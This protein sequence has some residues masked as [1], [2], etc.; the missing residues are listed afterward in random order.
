MKAV[1]K[2]LETFQ[3]A[4]V[5]NA[6]EFLSEAAM[7]KVVD[8]AGVQRPLSGASPFYAIIDL[9]CPDEQSESLIMT[10]FEKCAGEELIDDGVM[11][12]NRLQAAN[13]WRCREEISATISR[14]TP[15]KNDISVRVSRAPEFLQEIDEVVARH[16]PNFEVIWYGHMGDG[17][18]HLN[19]LKP[20]EISSSDFLAQC[21]KVNEW[22]YG[23]VRKHEGSVSAEHGIG[24]LKKNAL[25]YSRSQEEVRLMK[26]IKAVFDPDGIL[27]PGKIFD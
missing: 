13:L 16:Y 2:V 18:L 9:E 22:V 1:L 17:N 12:Q 25:R 7:A 10:L 27:N 23:V 6:F 19:I 26:A 15:Y 21:E 3:S 8:F 4:V 20:D 14:W 5:L 24:M 11:S